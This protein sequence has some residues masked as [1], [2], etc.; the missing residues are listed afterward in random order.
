MPLL[1]T[2]PKDLKSAYYRDSYLPMIIMAQ[3]VIVM[4]WI[5]PGC[6]SMDENKEMWGIHTMEYYLTIKKNKILSFPEKC[7]ELEIIILREIS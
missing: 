2:H 5:Q 6:S 3:S 4:L 7:M 1:D